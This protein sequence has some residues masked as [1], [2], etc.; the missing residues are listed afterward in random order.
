M[1]WLHDHG[2][3]WLIHS[4][5]VNGT[6]MLITCLE[7]RASAY[8]GD[9][10]ETSANALISWATLRASA[11]APSWP[12]PVVSLRTSPLPSHFTTSSL[13]P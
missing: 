1:N 12:P 4:R 8:T 6:P 11:W 13:R 7:A 5:E 9:T 3:R 2:L 10:A